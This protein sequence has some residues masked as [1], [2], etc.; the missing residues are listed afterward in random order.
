MGL[1]VFIERL[2]DGPSTVVEV[3]NLG[4]LFNDGQKGLIIEEKRHTH[5]WIR[6][7]IHH[8]WGRLVTPPSRD[9]DIG[10]R[11]FDRN[12]TALV[13]IKGIDREQGGMSEMIRMD[14]G[15]AQSMSINGPKDL[16]GL[17][18]MLRTSWASCTIAGRCRRVARSAERSSV[19]CSLARSKLC[20]DCG[21]A[22]WSTQGGYGPVGSFGWAM[23]LENQFG[24]GFDVPRC[25]WTS[26]PKGCLVR[27]WTHVD[28][29]RI[30][31]SGHDDATMAEPDDSSTKDKPGWINSEHTDLKPACETEDELEP[32]EVRVG[33]LIELS[34]TTLELDELSDTT[35]E[36]SELSDTEDGASLP[37]GRNEPCSAEGKNTSCFLVRLSPSKHSLFCWTYASYQATFRN[38]SFVGLV[39]HIKQQLKS[40]SIKRLSAALVSPFNT[41]VLPFGEF[42]S[43]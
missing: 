42:I 40:G 30:I 39:C 15:K 11:R 6:G 20:P 13:Q 22:I 2:L 24:L 23:G 37:A 17:N 31:D 25:I 10:P 7:R 35:L 43:L 29:P 18:R 14:H 5:H 26:V 19:K 1:Q 28:A 16:D 3:A 33:E 9:L 4:D 32:A 27:H 8:K 38:P 12:E 21:R 41:S 34:D 36:L